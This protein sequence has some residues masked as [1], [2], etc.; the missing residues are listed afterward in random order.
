ML[1]AE[2]NLRRPP[3]WRLSVTTV[4]PSEKTNPPV[5]Q[6]CLLRTEQSRLLVLNNA[7]GLHGWHR[8]LI[9][10]HPTV[11]AAASLEGCYVGLVFQGEIYVV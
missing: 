2:W 6:P 7:D 8:I 5:H 9:R 11:D 1:G 4:I 10:E 3:H